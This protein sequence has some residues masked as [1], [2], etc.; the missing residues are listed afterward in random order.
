MHRWINENKFKNQD[1]QLSRFLTSSSPQ[2]P[3][4]YGRDKEVPYFN[5]GSIG[6]GP[7]GLLASFNF[8]YLNPASFWDMR[9]HVVKFPG[10]WENEPR[11][12][13]VVRVHTA[14]WGL[15]AGFCCSAWCSFCLTQALRIALPPV[16]S[17]STPLRIIINSHCPL[18]DPLHHHPAQ[19]QQVALPPS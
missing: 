2:P 12:A 15:G 3:A 7:N 17:F 14:H 19:R 13:R 6:R 1:K 10:C 8:A 18:H 9:V 5:A 4:H 16:S 11:G